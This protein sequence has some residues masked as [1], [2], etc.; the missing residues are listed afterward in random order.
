MNKILPLLFATSFFLIIFFNVKNL[1]LDNSKN[2]SQSI[3]ENLKKDQLDVNDLSNNKE[4]KSKDKK[5]NK[6]NSVKEIPA[7]NSNTI[8]EKTIDKDKTKTSKNQKNNFINSEKKKVT[9]KNQVNDFTGTDTKLNLNDKKSNFLH[10]QSD[11]KPKNLEN[12][13]IK[14]NE[15]NPNLVDLSKSISKKIKVQFGAFSKM[16]NAENHKK[17]IYDEISIKFPEFKS[18]LEIS[19]ENKLF[20]VVMFAESELV[21]KSICDHSKSKKISCLVLVK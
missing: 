7:N 14:Q 6:V 5:P 18:K 19:K 21:A 11:G 10:K 13:K 8:N 3:N 12:P 9:T 20:K 16:I 2:V 4:I 1:T 15:D 17:K